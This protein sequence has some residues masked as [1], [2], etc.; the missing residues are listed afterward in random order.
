MSAL[1]KATHVCSTIKEQYRPRKKLFSFVVKPGSCSM[2]LITLSAQLNVLWSSQID[3]LFIHYCVFYPQKFCPEKI[4][5]YIRWTWSR[6]GKALTFTLFV[7]TEPLKLVSWTP[8]RF[9]SARFRR[10]QG[11]T[12]APPLLWLRFTHINIL[13][14]YLTA[15]LSTVGYLTQLHKEER[16]LEQMENESGSSHYDITVHTD[17]LLSVHLPSV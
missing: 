10:S 11:S 4:I 1:L 16:R 5:A 7:S 17:G 2:L 13:S 8:A 14:G 6:G 9:T 15:E 12:C 3:C